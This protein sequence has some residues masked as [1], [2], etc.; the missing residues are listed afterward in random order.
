MARP[1]SAARAVPVLALCLSAAGSLEA[2]DPAA[3]RLLV[4]SRKVSDPA[5]AGTVVLL[6]RHDSRGA[7]G[8][9]LNRQSEIPLSKLFPGLPSPAN[10]SDPVFLGGP[11]G[12]TGVI[13]LVRSSVAPA[14]A[15]LVF[16]DVLM[17]VNREPLS[18][19]IA[20]GA[21][22]DKFRAYLGYSGWT[23]GRLP[24]EVEA[25]SWHVLPATTR[26]VFD[27]DPPTL[28]PRLMRRIESLSAGRPAA[29][30]RSGA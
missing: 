23:T 20:A 21:R 11:V 16:S 29:T 10:A 15:G 3:G 19:T 2:V 6:I 14:G 9:I 1:S 26:L 30:R 28:W 5:F 12:R 4:A 17:I 7:M 13:G 27:P 18:Q 24:A 25:G 8:L 22:P